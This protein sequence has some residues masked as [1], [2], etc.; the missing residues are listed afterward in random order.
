MK[1]IKNGVGRVKKYLFFDTCALLNL[2]FIKMVDGE[3][4]IGVI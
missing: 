3:E 1:N 4:T 2:D